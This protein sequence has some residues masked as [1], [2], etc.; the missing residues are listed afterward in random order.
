MINQHPNIQEGGLSP[1]TD[2]SSTT[3][4]KRMSVSLSG[5]AAKLLA[6]LAESQGITQ[7]E[8]LRKAIATE[9]YLR[10]EMEQGAKVLLQKSS[11]D[12]REVVF[13]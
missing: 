8:A 3:S 4:P 11:K 13:R 12:I 7:N 10:Q 2:S 6:Q 5:D 9:A 1:P